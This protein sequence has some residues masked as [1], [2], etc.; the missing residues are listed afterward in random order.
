MTT[1]SPR[2]ISRILLPVSLA[3][4]L[5]ILGVGAG[6]LIHGPLERAP[7]SVD[8]SLGPLTRALD[9]ADR[10]QLGQSLRRDVMAGRRPAPPGRAARAV[11]L[12]RVLDAVRAD[13][14]AA[15]ALAAE[16]DAQ[17]ARADQWAKAGQTALLERLSAMTPAARAR[18][19]DRLE[20]EFHQR[21]GLPERRRRD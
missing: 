13:P 12:R 8:L 6:L 14:F 3:L 5:L 11:E 1:D 18:F 17:R 2:S 10:T 21:E 19:A 20:A 4:N 7:R 15:D 16:L 9:D